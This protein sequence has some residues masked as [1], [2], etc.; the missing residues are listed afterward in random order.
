MSQK[1][2]PSR[3]TYE[4]A[5][6]QSLTSWRSKL[7]ESKKFSHLDGSYKKAVVMIQNDDTRGIKQLMDQYPALKSWAD[8]DGG[9]LLSKAVFSKIILSDAMFLILIAA[10]CDA[11]VILGSEI[12]IVQH[13]IIA[14]H[15]NL[16]ILQMIAQSGNTIVLTKM[17]ASGKLVKAKNNVSEKY[18][19]YF[20]DVTEYCA[21]CR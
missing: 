5:D 2:Q 20:N 14:G 3:K 21:I 7:E 9:T 12:P 17:T 11:G 1:L 19:C 13:A 10:G 4:K 8:Y 6:A 15:T 18:A 16:V